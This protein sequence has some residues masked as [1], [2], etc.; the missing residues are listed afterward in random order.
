MH[1]R[2]DLDILPQPD[3]TTCGPTCLHAVYNYYGDSCSLQQIIDEVPKLEEGGTLAVYLA[4]HALKR[5]YEAVIYTY[6]LE[7]FDPTWFKAQAPNMLQRLQAQMVAKPR[8]KLAVATKAYLE[9]LKYGGKLRFED[10]TAKLIRGYL[11]RKI[12]VLAG[13]SATYLYGTSREYGSK[14]TYDDIRGV[15]SGHF[16]VLSGYAPKKRSV[17]VSDPL[18]PNPVSV[19][20]QYA[21]SIDRLVCSILLGSLTYDDNLLLIRPPKANKYSKGKRRSLCIS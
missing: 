5:G 8:K 14:M 18:L 3:E 13:L 9:F 19:H 20:N 7:I 21:V 12:P 15:A 1:R 16:V 10:L 11:G 6:N 17:W 4:L 2:L